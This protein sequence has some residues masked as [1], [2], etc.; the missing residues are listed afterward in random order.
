MLRPNEK[1]CAYSPALK[2]PS[3]APDWATAGY[4]MPG[5]CTVWDERL[6]TWMRRDAQFK[7]AILAANPAW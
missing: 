4:P 5:P 2:V 3:Y 1:L 7:A 6:R